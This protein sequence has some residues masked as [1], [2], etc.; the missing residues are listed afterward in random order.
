MM[1]SGLLIRMNTVLL[2]FIHSQF[3]SSVVRDTSN[4]LNAYKSGK[5]GATPNTGDYYIEA[6]LQFMRR[7]KKIGAK[8]TSIAF[9]VEGETEMWY[10]QMLKMNEEKERNVRINIKPEIPQKKKLEDQFK[11][12]CEMA[13]ENK[14]VFWILDLDTILKE[15]REWKGSKKSPLMVFLGYR[16]NLLESYDNVKVIVNNPCLE[17]WFLLHFEGKQKYYEKC[18]GARKRLKRYLSGYEKKE[19]YFKRPN[20]DIY[21]RLKPNLKAA[22]DN[23][24]SFG[25]F[26]VDEPK[27]AMCEMDVLFMM[28]ELRKCRGE[29]L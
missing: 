3:D 8:T 25:G 17:F 12:V 18:S 26:D 23:A 28:Q 27:K 6:E 2:N 29:K 11:L 24:N 20:N 21:L 4:V 5:L 22:I 16:N 15:T 13:A 19:R 9:V 7:S 10:L 14:T 1:Q